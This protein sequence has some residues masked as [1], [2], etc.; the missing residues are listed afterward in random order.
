MCRKIKSWL[1]TLTISISTAYGQIDSLPD[2]YLAGNIDSIVKANLIQTLKSQKALSG[3]VIL[4]NVKSDSVISLQSYVKKGNSYKFDTS[5]FNFPVEPQRLVYPVSM[6]LL[7]DEGKIE[8]KEMVDVDNGNAS[9]DGKNIYDA[10]RH[11]YKTIEFENLLALPSSVGIAKSAVSKFENEYKRYKKRYGNLLNYTFENDSISL[12]DIA[13]GTGYKISP[14]NIFSFYRTIAAGANYSGNYI[15]NN[16]F[17]LKRKKTLKEIDRCF[18]QTL[19]PGFRNDDNNLPFNSKTGNVMDINCFMGF[20]N[21]YSKDSS[22][23]Q[24]S[25]FFITYFPAEAPQY[26]CMSLINY[27]SFPVR[28]YGSHL[29]ENIFVPIYESYEKSENEQ[30]LKY[31]REKTRLN[32][33]RCSRTPVYDRKSGAEEI[34][35]HYIENGVEKY[36]VLYVPSKRYDD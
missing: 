12:A 36:K 14:G 13:T 8:L 7:L 35:L 15:T 19:N 31:T 26:V 9:I 1:L 21:T 32:I 2:I 18:H 23:K 20:N 25:G 4:A 28:F 29:A 24:V 34:V 16:S 33:T 3:F 6:A 30:L 17:S 5:L 11:G 22:T 27:S 10:E